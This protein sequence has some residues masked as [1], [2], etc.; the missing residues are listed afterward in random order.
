VMSP[1]DYAYLDFY[2]GDPAIE[3]PTYAML[4]LNQVYTFEPVPEGIDSS[5]ILGG[6]GNL[7]TESIPTFRHA[8]YM[9]WPRSFALSEVFWSPKHNRDWTDFIRRTEAHLQRFELADINYARSFYDAVITP[10]KDNEGNLV[11]QLGTELEG[12]NIYYS[13]DNTYPDSHSMLY[14]LGEKLSIPNDAETFRVITFRDGKPAGRI[15][16]VPLADLLKRI[17]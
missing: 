7:W 4:R 6:Q 16:S 13:F 9:L 10:A 12:L 5:F 11:I 14:K 2:Q 8:E 15:I 1:Y 3:P 17:P